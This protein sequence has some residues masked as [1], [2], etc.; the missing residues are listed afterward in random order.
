MDYS[1]QKDKQDKVIKKT[2]RNQN[3][4]DEL[5]VV[6]QENQD[7]LNQYEEVFA[8]ANTL[9]VE[10]EIAR[11]EF[12]QIF[13]A[14]GDPLWVVNEKYRILRINRSFIELLKLKN[15]K[16]VIGKKC[17]KVLS[18]PICQ[19][20][21][22][23]MKRIRT[24]SRRVELDIE[25]E[26]AEG[27]VNPFWLT[28]TPLFGLTYEIIGAV[29]HFK[30]ITERKSHEK[31]L[32]DANKKLETLAV[33]DSLTQLANR[34]IFDETIQKEWLRMRRDRQPLSVILGDIDFFKSYNDHY[35]HQEGDACLKAVADCIK[36]NV[37]RTADMVAR[38]GGEEFVILLPNTPSDGAFHIAEKVRTSVSAMKR[39]HVGSEV[40]GFV[41]ISLGIATI[42]PPKSGGSPAVLV[43]AADDALYASKEAGRNCVTVRDLS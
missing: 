25:L 40:K 20:K 33:T 24:G 3:I 1:L 36:N 18:S 11:I 38:Y 5:N 16:D 21:D 8:R 19:T 30:E 22:C 14:V 37:H 10:A 35:G 28:V 4:E 32:E 29:E 7:L 23:P 2:F 12:D 26:M 13:D 34:R 9:A 17:Y 27:S 15:K 43:T 42:I 39:E 6:K 41:T 31:A